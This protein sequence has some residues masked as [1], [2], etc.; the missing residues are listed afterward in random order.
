MFNIDDVWMILKGVNPLMHNV[1]KWSDTLHKS[2]SKC[3][4]IFKVCLTILVHYALK[5]LIAANTGS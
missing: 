1:P 3:C 4:K 2:C 5:V